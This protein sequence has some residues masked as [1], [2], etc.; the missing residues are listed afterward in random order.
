MRRLLDDVYLLTSTVGW[1]GVGIL[2]GTIYRGVFRSR[3]APDVPAGAMGEHIIDWTT[4]ENPSMQATYKSLRVGDLAQRWRRLP[5]SQKPAREKP[6][7]IV[8]A[9]PESGAPPGR[10]PEFGEYVYVEELPEVVT[11]V[12]PAYPEEAM[13]GIEG[14][15]QVQ[16][17]VLED[18]TVGD[19]RIVSSVPGLDEA[20]V[21][22]VRRWRFKPAMAKGVPVAVWVAVPVRF[23]LQH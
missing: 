18:G 11:K 3:G 16:A 20:A 23:R 8:V 6:A 1:E 19:C 12:M 5:D 7:P 2:E 9:P 4:P 15:V 22:A 13:A 21:A 17:L 10:R 14:T